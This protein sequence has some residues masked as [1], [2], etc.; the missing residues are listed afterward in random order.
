MTASSMV[1]FPDM[2]SA[3]YSVSSP[4]IP[5]CIPVVGVERGAQRRDVTRANDGVV[6]PILR[7]DVGARR[8]DVPG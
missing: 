4:P 1:T 7:P 3:M 8:R 6:V 2:S 5:N